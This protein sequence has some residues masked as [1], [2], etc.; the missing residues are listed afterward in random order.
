MSTPRQAIFNAF[1]T[2]DGDSHVFEVNRTDEAV[3]RD[4]FDT[5]LSA[6]AMAEMEWA[7][8]AWIGSRLVRAMDRTGVGPVK[9]EVAVTVRLDGEAAS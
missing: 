7:I 8:T 9:V 5:T 6:D 3:L 2:T 4:G 1:L